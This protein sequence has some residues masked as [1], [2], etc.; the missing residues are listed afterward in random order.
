[1]RAWE[2]T[3]AMLDVA[4][5]EGREL[6]GEEEASYQRATEDINT[7]DER[8]KG[9]MESERSLQEAERKFAEIS[10]ERPA[11]VQDKGDELRSWLKGETASRS[12]DL[13]PEGRVDFRATGMTVGIPTGTPAAGGNTVK[14]SFYERLIQHLIV[15]SGVLQ[16]N[17][18]VLNTATGEALQIPKTTA[19]SSAATILN[20][21]SSNEAV[22]LSENSP[23][24]GQAL[25]NSYKYGFLMT[26]SHE[27][28]NDTSVDLEGYL[29]MQAGRALGNGFGADLVKGSGTN[30]PNGVATAVTSGVSFATGKKDIT[31]DDLMDLFYSLI[32]PYRDSPSCHWLMH[33]TTVGAIRKL[34]DSTGQYI[35]QPALTAG[36]PDMILGKP[37][38]TD[39]N[40]D[41]TSVFAKKP[42]LFGDF[43]TYFVRMVEAIRFERSLDFHFDTD[44]VTFRAILRGDG[45]LIDTTGA[46]KAIITPAS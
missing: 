30:A 40:M 42:V 16:T 1:M 7:L 36:A 35:W 46:I 19:H 11:A 23:T 31:T 4:S 38:T 45:D 22:A 25:L 37:V 26:I 32:A 29:S 28:L 14:T 13:R 9:F 12:Y 43:S 6:T 18:T 20:V 3:K 27:L 10:V 15:N 24:F 5:E 2:Q 17:P 8:I 33:D 21:S 41:L 39:P 44:V 34:K